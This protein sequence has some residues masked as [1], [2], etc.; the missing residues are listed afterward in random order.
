MMTLS[1]SSLKAKLIED[2]DTCNYARC[3]RT[4]VGVSALCQVRIR[5]SA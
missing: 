5:T 3:G 1:P 4:D 2:K